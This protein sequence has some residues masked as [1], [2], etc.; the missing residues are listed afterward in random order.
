M[1]ISAVLAQKKFLALFVFLSVLIG[2]FYF[3]VTGVYIVSLGQFIETLEPLRLVL[4]VLIS[5]LTALAITLM[6][7]KRK[8]PLVCSQNAPAFLGSLLGLFTTSCPI[9]FPLLLSIIG[10]GG[11]FALTVS[12][13]AVPLQL[14][15]IVLLLVSLWLTVK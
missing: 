3:I 8:Q 15:S 9:C 12:Q 13:N 2:I 4:I 11:S 14:A 7:Y 1:K 10:V 5:I 6:F